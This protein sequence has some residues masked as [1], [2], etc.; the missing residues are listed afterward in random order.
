MDKDLIVRSVNTGNDVS[1]NKFNLQVGAGS[2][3]AFNNCAGKSGSMF[4]GFTDV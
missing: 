4:P 3:D 1:G 2:A